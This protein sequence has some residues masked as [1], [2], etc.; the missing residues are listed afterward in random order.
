MCRKWA[1]FF[2][3]LLGVAILS[4]RPSVEPWFLVVNQP[5]LWSPGA[6]ANGAGSWPTPIFDT[7]IESLVTY[8]MKNIMLYLIWICVINRNQWIGG[9]FQTFWFPTCLFENW[10]VFFSNGFRPASQFCCCYGSYL[11]SF[12]LDDPHQRPMVFSRLK[13]FQRLVGYGLNMVEHKYKIEHNHILEIL[14]ITMYIISIGTTPEL[15]WY[16]NWSK[17]V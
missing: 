17:E 9:L 1:R 4:R 5:I 8:L 12:C 15:S 10:R 7:S 6:M 11:A 3:K 16:K 14:T 13:K 2:I